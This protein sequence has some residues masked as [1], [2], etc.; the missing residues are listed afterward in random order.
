MKRFVFVMVSA[1]ALVSILVLKTANKRSDD[2]TKVVKISHVAVPKTVSSENSAI[3]IEESL[4]IDLDRLQGKAAEQ[5]VTYKQIAIVRKAA[6]DYAKDSK[7][8]NQQRDRIFYNK[9]TVDG[10][11]SLSDEERQTLE[12]LNRRAEES[13]RRFLTSYQTIK[14]VMP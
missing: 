2:E 6:E 7:F 8:L 13:Q 1:V 12:S 14:K 10:Q 3:S 9:K 11:V 4:K 5:N